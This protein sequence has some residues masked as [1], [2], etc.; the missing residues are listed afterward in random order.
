[1]D[2]QNPRIIVIGCGTTGA[3]DD[4]VAIE[5]IAE[6]R[7][8]DD[9][10]CEFLAYEGSCPAGFLSEFPPDALVVFID[11]VH[12]QKN[13]GSVHCLK[14]PSRSSRMRHLQ[15]E[16]TD[17]L[18]EEIERATQRNGAAPKMFLLGVEVSE[19][20]PGTGLSERARKAV[21][22]LVSNFPRYRKLAKDL[23]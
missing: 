16:G 23:A 15:S 2:Q 5:V 22:E 10:G 11:S 14:L 9:A 18:Q 8:I 20:I 13:P 4:A 21:L 17:R 19:T 6:L 7:K 3:G 12:K 1:M